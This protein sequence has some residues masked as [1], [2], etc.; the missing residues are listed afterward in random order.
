[1]REAKCKQ[2]TKRKGGGEATNKVP[3]LAQ[4]FVALS[5]S[6]P[7]GNEEGKRE[8]A[9]DQPKEKPSGEQGQ[10]WQVEKDQTTNRFASSSLLTLRGPG[11]PKGSDL[12]VAARREGK[13]KGRKSCSALVS[14]GSVRFVRNKTTHPQNKQC[15]LHRPSEAVVKRQPNW[16]N[17]SKRNKRQQGI[18]SK[19][20]K[21]CHTT[22][23]VVLVVHKSSHLNESGDA[24]FFAPR[25]GYPGVSFGSTSLIL[26]RK[27]T[28]RRSWK[29]L[30]FLIPCRPTYIKYRCMN[31]IFSSLRAQGVHYFLV[32]GVFESIVTTWAHRLQRRIRASRPTRGSPVSASHCPFFTCAGRAH[33]RT[34]SCEALFR[35]TED[36]RVA[37]SYARRQ[38]AHRPAPPG[39]S[40]FAGTGKLL[41]VGG[42]TKGQ[43]GEGSIA[44]L[45]CALCTVSQV[46]EFLLLQLLQPSR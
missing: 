11:A 26:L 29:R 10:A 24:W 8:C 41:L 6:L 37:P 31:C 38:P 1:V 17:G 23:R 18:A 43:P 22:C 12:A 16:F 14:P 36:R 39:S 7:T 42:I 9:E 34:S 32:C 20:W 25:D 19:S 33:P 30:A 44:L 3:H 27:N 13:T 46:I 40:L 28:L 5:P 35:E 21:A 45:F 4:T 2:G 15:V